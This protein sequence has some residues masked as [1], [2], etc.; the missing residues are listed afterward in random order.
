MIAHAAGVRGKIP[1]FVWLLRNVAEQIMHHLA[2]RMNHHRQGLCWNEDKEEADQT[3]CRS[4]E[5]TRQKEI[6]EFSSCEPQKQLNI[7]HSG[8]VFVGSFAPRWHS[9]SNLTVQP[10]STTPIFI[11]QF[12]SLQPQRQARGLFPA[13]KLLS[14]WS[15]TQPEAEK[16]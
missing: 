8:T 2:R 7:N 13:R 10:A 15:Q 9:P 5:D 6:K 16:K 14:R 1:M 11:M 3:Y 12:V 4:S